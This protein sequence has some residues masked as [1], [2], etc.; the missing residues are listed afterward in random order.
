MSRSAK[1]SKMMSFTLEPQVYAQIKNASA[2]EKRSMG[3]IVREVL[4]GKFPS[5]VSVDSAPQGVST[6]T[7]ELVSEE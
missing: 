1:F 3:A 7:V 6:E 2:V 5:D 4:S